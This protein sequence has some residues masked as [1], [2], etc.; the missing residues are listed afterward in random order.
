[1]ADRALLERVLVLHELDR[2]QQAGAPGRGQQ[3]GPVATSTTAGT[4]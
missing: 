1:M 2:G 3:A 4:R